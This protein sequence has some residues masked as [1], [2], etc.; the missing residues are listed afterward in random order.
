MQAAW[1]KGQGQTMHAVKDVQT[2]ECAFKHGTNVE[3]SS[4]RRECVEGTKVSRYVMQK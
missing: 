2:E 1:S 4:E 3:Y